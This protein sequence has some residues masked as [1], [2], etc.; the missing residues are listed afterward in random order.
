MRNTTRRR[1]YVQKLMAT[2]GLPA[3][4]TVAGAATLLALS[5]LGAAGTNFNPYAD[6]FTGADGD[7]PDGTKW[8][9]FG[10]TGATDRIV[11]NAARLTLGTLGGYGD[12][13]TM[14]SLL[15]NRLNG[16]VSFTATSL[17]AAECYFQAVLRAQSADSSMGDSEAYRIEINNGDGYVSLA[18]RLNGNTTGLGG[19]N[20]TGFGQ[21]VPVHIEFSV[22]GSAITVYG[23]T[24]TTR[25]ASP[26]ISVTDASLS[27]AGRTGFQLLGGGAAAA[28]A[29]SVDDWAI[30]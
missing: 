4:A 24:G 26:N 3:F 29:W 5:T 15:P 18:Y 14:V 27:K 10:S 7:L 12:K 19:F 17:S 6:S 21:G 9:L 28:S 1:S 20:I 16:G 22:I 8:S 13:A 23:Y 11:G 30:L 2:T 25:P